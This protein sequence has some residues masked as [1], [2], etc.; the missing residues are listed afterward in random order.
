[1]RGVRPRAG[2]ALAALL[3]LAGAVTAAPPPVV[4]PRPA[5]VERRLA[6]MGTAL[7]VTVE[8]G[9]RAAGLAASER[10]V[11]AVE[12]AEARL[13]TWRQNSELARLNRS[14]AGAA[15]ALSP[16]LAADLRGAFDC[17]RSTGGA[18]DPTVGPLVAA[19][20]LRTGGRLPSAAELARAVAATGYPQLELAGRSAVRRQPGL[21][22]EEGGWGKGAALRDALAALTA[23]PA[24]GG[25]SRALLD[26]GGQVAVWS[27]AA[28]GAAWTVDVADPRRRER[29][30][31]A[32]RLDRG[33]LSTSGNSERAVEVGGRRYGHLLDPRSGRPAPDVGSVT[34]WAADPLVADCLSTGL[35]VMGAERALSWAAAHPEIE[36]LILTPANGRLVARASRGL[37]GR[38]TMLTADV[39]LERQSP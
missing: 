29:P 38:L 17:A 6:L 27:A 36:V 7:A 30:V 14:P 32:V 15:F 33:S 35:F 37:R 9:D 28:G 39:I 10:A 13:S 18:F 1:M 23:T 3:G 20:G 25:A 8:A 12:A 21:I 11:A 34:V 31:I 16:A 22:I 2:C 4:S 24:A 26:L 19:W 5:V